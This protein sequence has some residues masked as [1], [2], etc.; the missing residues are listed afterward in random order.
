MI[1]R[2][3][4]HKNRKYKDIKKFFVIALNLMRQ[5]FYQLYDICLDLYT[6]IFRACSKCTSTRIWSLTTK[7]PK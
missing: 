2:N 5:F 1:N 4:Y 3:E 7:I 6:S